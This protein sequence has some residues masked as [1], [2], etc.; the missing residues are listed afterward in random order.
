[1]DMKR[2]N[3]GHFYDGEKFSKC[4]YCQGTNGT[5]DQTI[6]GTVAEPTAAPVSM[7][8]TSPASMEDINSFST[9]DNGEGKTIGIFKKSSNHDP[10]VGWLV[11]IKG[12]HYGESFTLK[13]GR[14]FI[15]RG[16]DMDV[17]LSADESV[18]RNKH[19]VL[20][21][22]P[23]ANQFFIQPGESRELTYLNEDVLLESKLLHPHDRICLGNSELLFIPLCSSEFRWEDEKESN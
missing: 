8:A 3:R 22:D 20:L 7:P 2:C 18:S 9:I 14:N 23:K 4:P 13:T 6:P 16:R 1:M 15:G 21:Y 5:V 17:V 19:A 10:V 12:K 11:G